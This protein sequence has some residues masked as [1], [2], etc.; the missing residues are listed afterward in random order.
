MAN[1]VRTGSSKELLAAGNTAMLRGGGG[2]GGRGGQRPA[3]L[4][5]LWD[6]T[7]RPAWKIAVEANKAAV[8][9][10]GARAFE[11]HLLTLEGSGRDFMFN[12]QGMPNEAFWQ[13]GLAAPVTA[14]AVKAAAVTRWAVERRAKILEWAQGAADEKVRTAAETWLKRAPVRRSTAP[15][16]TVTVTTPAA[17]SRTFTS[18]PERAA[19]ERVRFYRRALGAWA[20]LVAAGETEALEQLR[21]LQA[22]ERT[23]L[24]KA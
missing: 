22:L 6:E 5:K 17:P 16:P 1:V 15:A 20:F 8:L 11:K 9:P 13:S 21:A 2:R 10:A 24:P 19:R 18:A 23:S 7:I 12:Q 3:D 4:A 14:D